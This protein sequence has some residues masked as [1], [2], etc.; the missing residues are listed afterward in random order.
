MKPLREKPPTRIEVA[1]PEPHDLPGIVCC[2][3]DYRFHVFGTSAV[4]D[5][6]FSS[7]DV[8][9]VRNR[10]CSIDL[11]EKSWVAR[12][13]ERVLG[14]CCW[15]WK[16]RAAGTAGTLLISVLEKARS[17]GVGSLLQDRRLCEMV[18][19]GAREVHTLS[20][21]PD[22]IRWYQERYGYDLVE[23]EPIH[24]CIHAFR[25][26]GHTFWGVHRGHVGRD[27]L[28]HLRL[29]LSVWQRTIRSSAAH[30]GAL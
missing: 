21:H 5:P 10:I 4:A 30:Y 29:D 3:A 11:R 19:C 28:A 13:G 18:D 6:D 24:H 16:D 25:L 7:D 26:D 15:G 17:L 12:C 22:A 9:Q 27:Q 8:L 1:R 2:L 20:D 14:F 23:Y